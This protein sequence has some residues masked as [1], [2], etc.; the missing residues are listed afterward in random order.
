MTKTQK[1]KYQSKRETPLKNC[2]ASLSQI[3]SK[4]KEEK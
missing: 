2:G 4:Q 1:N 3:F